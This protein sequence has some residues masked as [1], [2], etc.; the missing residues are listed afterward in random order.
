MKTKIA[1]ALIMGIITTGIISFTLV[2]V[3]IGYGGRFLQIWLRS[4]ALAYLVVIPAILIIGPQVQKLV[5][6][7][8]K[9]KTTTHESE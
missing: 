1:F 2:S 5:D 6:N 4:W 9:S 7:L 8:F 3:N